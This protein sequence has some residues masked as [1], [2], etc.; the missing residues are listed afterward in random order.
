[1]LIRFLLFVVLALFV[2]RSIWRLFEGIVEGA[3]GTRRADGRV[4]FPNAARR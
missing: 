2:L 1:M 3:T 4:A